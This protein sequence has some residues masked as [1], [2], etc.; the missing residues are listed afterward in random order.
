LGPVFWVYISETCSDKGLSIAVITNWAGSFCVSIVV[1]FMFSAVSAYGFGIFGLIAVAGFF[2]FLI[3]M[4]ETKGLSI[5][6][7]K[8]I[9]SHPS[10]AENQFLEE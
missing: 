5:D 6:Q 1:P 10:E 8:K 7:C 4:K 9:Y 2:F 3:F